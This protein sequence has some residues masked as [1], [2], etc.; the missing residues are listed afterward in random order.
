MRVKE[1]KGVY[2]LFFL[3]SMHTN[4]R[5]KDKVKRVVHSMVLVSHQKESFRSAAWA[6]S[7]C[8]ATNTNW[9][10]DHLRFVFVHVTHCL[11]FYG[12]YL[13][14]RQNKWILQKAFQPYF[15]MSSDHA[16]SIRRHSM[17]LSRL[18]ET[19][20]WVALLRC[21]RICAFGQVAK[22]SIGHGNKR[23]ILVWACTPSEP[24]VL[25]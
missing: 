9:Q 18:S 8:S 13:P 16:Q 20:A 25:F 5:W 6:M 17:N 23:T 14:I 21:C 11:F 4:P 1:S 7:V 3:W 10:M 15:G 2:F 12:P 19:K 24:V 22:W